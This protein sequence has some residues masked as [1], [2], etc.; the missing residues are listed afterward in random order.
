M[1]SLTDNPLVQQI[2]QRGKWP[3]LRMAVLIGV[4]LGLLSVIVIAGAILRMPADGIFATWLMALGWLIVLVSPAVVG[5]VAGVSTARTVSSEAFELVRL[6][7]LPEREIVRGLVG[8]A[9]YRLRILIGLNVTA[10]PLIVLGMIYLTLVVT[11]IFCTITCSTLMYAGSPC[12]CEP[13]P[14]F[15]PP[16]AWL[17][18]LIVVAGL[19]GMIGL[20]AALGVALGLNIK[21]GGTAGSITAIIM[22]PLTLGGAYLMLLLSGGGWV[23]LGPDHL[24]NDL[25]LVWGVLLSMILSLLVSALPYC[26]AAGMMRLSRRWIK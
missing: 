2:A 6:T 4:G 10:L 11:Q 19:W 16:A 21:K 23:V 22:L 14:V 25:P 26:L 12:V 18:L 15:G 1:A 7:N 13:W 3:S 5:M 17:T 24:F 8:G 9:L 20:A